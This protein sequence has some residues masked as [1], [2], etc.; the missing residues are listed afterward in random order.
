MTLSAYRARHAR[1][2]SSA[3]ELADYFVNHYYDRIPLEWFDRQIKE[4]LGIDVYAAE[5]PKDRGYKMN[6]KDNIRLLVIRVEDLN[7]C[8]GSA[9]R[10]FL[11]IPVFGMQIRT[12]SRSP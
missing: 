1:K 4:P 6:E 12:W 10:E 3:Q 7:G 2:D 11:R 8:V 9:L 5:F